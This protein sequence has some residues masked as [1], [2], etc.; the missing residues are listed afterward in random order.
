[1]DIFFYGFALGAVVSPFLV[2]FAKLGYKKL[3]GKL[4]TV[5]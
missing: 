1:M 4:G 2:Y 3:K 5:E